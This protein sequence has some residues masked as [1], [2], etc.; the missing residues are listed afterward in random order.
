MTIVDFFLKKSAD[1]KVHTCQ[2]MGDVYTQ[3]QSN[4]LGYKNH[5]SCKIL[6]KFSL[7]LHFLQ[8]SYKLYK[9]RKFCKFVTMSNISY[10]ILIR[11]LQKSHFFS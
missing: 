8:E 3:N 7:T 6:P 9:N 5:K 10:K 11:F 1:W 2:K 4:S